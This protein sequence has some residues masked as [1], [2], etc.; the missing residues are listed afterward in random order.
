MGD[1]S[2]LMTV[3]TLCASVREVAIQEP[4]SDHGDK[5]V[6][7]GTNLIKSVQIPSKTLN[8]HTILL[9]YYNG[10]DRYKINTVNEAKVD[11]LPA[12]CDVT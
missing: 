8:V 2:E 6:M 10:S 11:L 7:L 4:S 3:F 5:S 9:I 1:Q 12:I